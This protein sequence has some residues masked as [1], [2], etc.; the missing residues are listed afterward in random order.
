MPPANY[1]SHLYAI[2]TARFI[3]PKCF[4]TLKIL[5]YPHNQNSLNVTV[6]AYLDDVHTDSYDMTP[7][8]PEAPWL[9]FTSAQG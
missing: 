7:K 3:D 1:Q 8:S 9:R 5:R 2:S 6:K 4:A